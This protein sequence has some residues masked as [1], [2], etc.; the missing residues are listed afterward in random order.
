MKSKV[1][2]QPS[3]V[4]DEFVQNVDQNICER[5]CSTVSEIWVN[6]HK[7]CTLLFRII[8][9]ILGCHKFAQ[10][11]LQKCSWVKTGFRAVKELDAYIFTRQVKKV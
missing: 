6:F 5:Q 3:M 4:S 9:D 7:F 2:S 1:V 8:T 11:G 10:D